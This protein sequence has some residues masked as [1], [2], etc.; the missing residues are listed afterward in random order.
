MQGPRLVEQPAIDSN[1]NV[2]LWNGDIFSG[3]LVSF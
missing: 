3:D 1:G 2:L